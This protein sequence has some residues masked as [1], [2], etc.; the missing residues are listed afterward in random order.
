MKIKDRKNIIPYLIKK[1]DENIKNIHRFSKIIVT[2]QVISNFTNS[3][4]ETIEPGINYRM[5]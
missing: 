3:N 2:F 1:K 5:L 4:Q